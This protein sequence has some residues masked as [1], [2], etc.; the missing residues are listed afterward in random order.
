MNSFQGNLSEYALGPVEHFLSTE[1]RPEILAQ[2][3]V[4]ASVPVFT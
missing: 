4:S 1:G 2:A 3:E